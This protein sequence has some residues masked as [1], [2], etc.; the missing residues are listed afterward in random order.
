M[1]HPL[2]ERAGAFSNGLI[3]IDTIPI[4]PVR[5]GIC[6]GEGEWALSQ[7]KAI[8]GLSDG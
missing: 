3:P 8:D 5:I 4:S 1:K 2:D 6:S 7:D